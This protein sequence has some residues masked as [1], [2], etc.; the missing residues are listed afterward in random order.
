MN[1]E[2]PIH[3]ELV[4]SFTKVDRKAPEIM[5]A[6]V[7]APVYK[8]QGRV[9]ARPAITGETI[10]TVLSSGATETVN[11]AKD[12][13]WIMTNPSGERYVISSEKFFDRYEATAEDGV[14]SAKGHC[15]AIKNPFGK[16]IEIM[17]SWGKP[18]TG[19]EDCMLADTCD[20][21][22]NSMGG[23]PYIIQATAFAETYKPIA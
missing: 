7:E 4:M 5:S 18:Q 23:E 2:Q 12:G 17:A 8:K 3:K 14:Y 1:T 19:D 20:G 9:Q 11:T 13:D 10:T 15:R 22:G 21:D 6:L 16:P